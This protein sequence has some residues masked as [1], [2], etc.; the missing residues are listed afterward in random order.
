MKKKRPRELGKELDTGVA[1]AVSANAGVEGGRSEAR[2]QIY[3]Q[4]SL[5][6]VLATGDQRSTL[7]VGT[8]LHTAVGAQAHIPAF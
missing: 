7:H 2:A 5:T 3:T 4:A 1:V 6:G 8:D